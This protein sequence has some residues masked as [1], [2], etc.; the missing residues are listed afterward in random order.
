MSVVDDQTKLKN[1]CQRNY[2]A[3]CVWFLNSYWQKISSDKEGPETFW[4]YAAKCTELDEKKKQDGCE[5]DEFQAHRF[6][7]GFKETIT[8]VSLRDQIRAIGINKFNFIP[9]THFLIIKFKAN[10]N[11]LVNAPQGS[12]EEIQKAQ[13]LLDDARNKVAELEKAIAELNAQERAYN[14]KKDDL[15]RKS[16]DESSSMVARNKAKNE[17]AQHLAEDPLPLRKAKL[18]SEAAFKKAEKA[19]QDAQNYLDEVKKNA[20]GGKGALWWI[21]RE[22]E[23]AKKYMPQS[24]GGVPKKG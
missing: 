16:G 24:K 10:W 20:T 17:L 9:L 19:L 11:E 6:F 18:T 2:K 8:V 4:K 21:E 13:M 1:L 22:L 12:D 14:Q 5:L 3:Q 23:E 15:T 7:E